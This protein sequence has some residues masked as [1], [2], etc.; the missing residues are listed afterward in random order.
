MVMDKRHKKI[1]ILFWLAIL[2]I[3][4]FLTYANS[5]NNQFLAGD[6]E[7]IVL[8]NNYLRD[9][10]FLPRF[11][12]QNYKAG[13]GTIS[14]FW[15]PFQILVYS[16]IVHTIGIKPW[17][18]HFSSIL[19]HSLCGVL[20]YS[21]ILGLSREKIPLSIAGLSVLAW[22]VHPI[23]NEELAVTT[24][25]ASPSYLF[26]ILVGL[27]SF[28]TFE[29]MYRREK[30]CQ[31]LRPATRLSAKPRAFGGGTQ[32]DN[33]KI[34]WIWYAAS[35]IGF[36]FSLASKES[37]VIFPLLLLGLHVTGIK[38][39]AFKN[40]GW[41]RFILNHAPFWALAFIYVLSRLTIL[42]FNNTL[43]FYG[44]ANV[45]TE[46]FAYRLYTLFT[47]LAHGLRVTFFPFGLHPERS[48]QVFIEFFS[49]PVFGPFLLIVALC[50]LAVI[51]YRKNPLFGFG[52]FWYFAGYL[53]MSNLAAQI[54]ALV[55]DHWFYAPSAGI[56]LSI[57]AL[58]EIK[59]IRKILFI[60]LTGMVI[61]FSIITFSR[62]RHWRDTE[63]ASR[64]IL[65]YEPLSAK[66]W[67]NLAMA[68]SD[69]S[70]NQQAINCYL[71]AVELS[72]VYPQTHHNLANSYL[73]LGKYD[74]A[75]REYFKAVE[76]DDKFYYSY[77][78]LGKLYLFKGQKEKA[79]DYFTKA[80]QIYPYLNE[81][82]EILK[83][84]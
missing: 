66:T 28:I 4:P 51:N 14:N 41:K 65:R 50:A 53:P 40:P 52:I 8:R 12:T 73:A 33:L 57:A 84:M 29:K 27:I 21:I 54:N 67:N 38:T 80:L 61:I 15:R 81:V 56:F 3:A 83:G 19:F 5:F 26:W 9:W 75:E 35:I 59:S 32:N 79:K 49:W 71:K 70:D 82:K 24:G 42:N 45:F 78:N 30:S 10:K 58:A 64:Y 13:A 47:V 55:W 1:I 23:H 36:A 48:W 22:L 60:F 46:N 43:N 63:S 77:I 39:G 44:Q 76:L 7:E 11:F 16:V 17:A 69:K 6:D 31:I 74:L 20:L 62:S 34:A 72:D 68:L 2:F 25:I 18:F 37:S